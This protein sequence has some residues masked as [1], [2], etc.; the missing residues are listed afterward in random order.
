M[1]QDKVIIPAVSLG[2]FAKGMLHQQ[3]NAVP[4]GISS[5]G[6][7]LRPPEDT[8]LFLSFEKFRGP[9]T[10]N[11]NP[12]H[13]A[14][15]EIKS[16]SLVF[17]SPAKITFPEEGIQINLE[18]AEVW[19]ASVPSGKLPAETSRSRL[20][21]TIEQTLRLTERNNSQDLFNSV[22]PGN[23]IHIPDIPSFDHHLTQFLA[24][25]EQ[26]KS[27]MGGEELSSLLGLGS[28]LTPL[29]DDLILG[30]ILTL[31]RW[32][33]VLI[34]GQGLEELNDNLLI[35]AKEKTTALS[36]SLLSCAI[37]GAADERLLA[38]LDSFFSGDESSPR[39][40][41]NLL[42]WGSSSG[43]G[44]LAGMVSVLARLI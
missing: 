14:I 20:E 3:E 29:G 41:D 37:E 40:L 18:N 32:G 31:N 13:G 21:S 17:L 26:N 16:D 2:K 9:L 35:N 6:L 10:V 24:A 12:K 4:A 7:Y 1:P 22:L 42:K 30:V 28:G 43:I 33:Q 39:D 23:T 5:R 36:A 38:V 19:N 34:P 27:T 8:I 11:I 15:P 25:L 44:V